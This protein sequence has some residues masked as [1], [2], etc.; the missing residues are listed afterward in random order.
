MEVSTI[1]SIV[2]LS[3]SIS[4]FAFV[5]LYFFIRKQEKRKEE[6]KKTSAELGRMRELLE[7]KIYGINERLIQNEERWRD[8]NH[9]LLN[10]KR[11]AIDR[12]N[13]SSN[14][15]KYSKFLKVNGINETDLIEDENLIF[16]LT[17]FNNKFREDYLMVKDVCTNLNYHC[18][19]G[20]ENYFNVKG[21]IF[22]EMLKLI[23]KSSIVIANL[24]GRNPN[25]MYE[26]GIAHALDKRVILIA[27]KPERLELPIDIQSK[28]FLVYAD[29]NQLKNDLKKILLNLR[30]T[31][32]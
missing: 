6:Q 30:N 7:D 2:I 5:L 24:N 20:D 11:I 4:A 17:P 10:Q 16:M 27:S 25:V 13:D 22:P 28:M 9:L 12:I 23:V 31:N 19:R 26:L 1:L 29:K 3:I 15:V 14:Y 21:D 18:L 32:G 8:V